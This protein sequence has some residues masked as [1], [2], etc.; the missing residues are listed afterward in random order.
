MPLHFAPRPKLSYTKGFERYVLSLSAL[1]ITISDISGLSH[2]GRDTV[3]DIQKRYL[4]KKYQLPDLKD[5]LL[6]PERPPVLPRGS[7]L[8]GT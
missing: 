6:L 2:A 1:N 8:R 5:V 3:K 7:A 4:S